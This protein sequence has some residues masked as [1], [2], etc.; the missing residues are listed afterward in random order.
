MYP[1]AAHCSTRLTNSGLSP[2]RPQRPGQ[3]FA[4]KQSRRIL[5]PPNRDA[6]Q[7][8]PRT[9]N[10]RCTTPPLLRRGAAPPQSGSRLPRLPLP[11]RRD[12]PAES[13]GLT[14]QDAESTDWGG[15]GRLLEN[16]GPSML[17]PS[18]NNH[19]API[20]S[21]YSISLSCHRSPLH[22]RPSDEPQSCRPAWKTLK[23][24]APPTGG[25]PPKISARR[26]P[27]PAPFGL[28]TTAAI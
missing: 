10:N 11:A 27:C 18:D 20:L 16:A 24:S 26:S 21:C 25:G 15:G 17:L 9:C 2:L 12:F 6:I 7:W 4:S 19:Q 23:C 1:L 8:T 13:E 22:R 3:N 14:R 5:R 28:G